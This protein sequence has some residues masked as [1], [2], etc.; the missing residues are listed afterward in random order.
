MT[1][2]VEYNVVESRR[3]SPCREANVEDGDVFGASTRHFDLTRVPRVVS[4]DCLQ[5]AAIIR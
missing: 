5:H 2:S 4:L 1:L 3:L